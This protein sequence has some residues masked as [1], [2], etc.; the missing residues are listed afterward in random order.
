ML[1][2]AREDGHILIVVAARLQCLCLFNVFCSPA[3]C[4]MVDNTGV[5]LHN[6]NGEKNVDIQTVYTGTLRFYESELVSD[7]NY[8]FN[9]KSLMGTLRVRD[10]YLSYLVRG[11]L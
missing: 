9:N 4:A 10:N 11:M 3:S 2:K 7:I 5:L 8:H 1:Y 6:M